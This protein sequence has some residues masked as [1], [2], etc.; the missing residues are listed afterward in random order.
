MKKIIVKTVL[1]L[2]S[3]IAPASL[4]AAGTF[5]E[6]W[7]VIGKLNRLESGGILFDSWEGE[8]DIFGYNEDEKCDEKSYECFTPVSEK[9]R[10]SI[11]KDNT[12]VIQFLKDKVDAGGFLV[13]FRRHRVEPVSLSTKIEI[14]DAVAKMADLPE[15]FTLRQTSKKTGSRNFSLHGE[16]LRLEYQG[17]AV[18]TYEG[19]Y[20][21][22]KTQKVHPFSVTDKA[23]AE[24]IW[25]SMRI[26]K[27]CYIGISVAIVTGFRKSDHDV[28]EINFESAPGLN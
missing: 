4:F 19:L 11:R 17:V 18:G 13:Q 25:K 16:I 28:F 9:M 15:G 20:L 21:D 22:H 5:S 8:A 26:E 23:M 24:Y 12:K 6:G 7:I 10:F 14:I 1:L 3:M 2:V 27:P